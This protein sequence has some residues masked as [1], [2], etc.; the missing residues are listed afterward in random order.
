MPRH[1][2]RSARAL[3][4]KGV[5]RDKGPALAVAVVLVGIVA[6]VAAAG[7]MVYGTQ[8]LGSASSQTADAATDV[9]GKPVVHAS[10]AVAADGVVE[11]LHLYVGVDAGSLDLA[12][13]EL[14][15]ERFQEGVGFRYGGGIE[16]V[17]QRDDDGSATSSAPSLGRGDLVELVVPLADSDLALVPGDT[18]VVRW[19]GSGA[20]APPVQGRVPASAGGSIL[21]LSLG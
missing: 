17:V 18:F 9:A 3:E 19:M 10:H 13:L 12:G 15:V 21:P 5:R 1:A 6:S 16:V 11:S 8:T 4:R 2:N 7:L 20:E 14:R